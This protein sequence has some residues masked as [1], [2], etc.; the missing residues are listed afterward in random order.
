MQDN[1][2]ITVAQLFL[3]NRQ[4][5][6]Q[7]YHLR[8]CS[9]ATAVTDLHLNKLPINFGIN[10]L[11]FNKKNDNLLEKVAVTAK[12]CNENCIK[13]E[14]ILQTIHRHC[15]KSANKNMSDLN[16]I[17]N[18]VNYTYFANLTQN[19][20]KYFLEEA[21]LSLM[22]GRAVFR[23]PVIAVTYPLWSPTASTDD[24]DICDENI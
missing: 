22:R 5:K 20:V 3:P 6:N 13:L 21:R 24:Q 17:Y 18:I 12:L 14:F 9:A 15:E 23:C 11:K 8:T 16:V 2:A 1:L 7:K 10:A 19:C 4:A